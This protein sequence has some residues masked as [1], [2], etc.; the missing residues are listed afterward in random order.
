MSKLSRSERVRVIREERNK[1]MIEM[2][3]EKIRKQQEL[4]DHKSGA[5]YIND[6]CNPSPYSSSCTQGPSYRDSLWHEK[7]RPIEAEPI[8]PQPVGAPS[9]VPIQPRQWR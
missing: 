1:A 7:L 4:I 5:S 6:G 8:A 3:I 2:K 9:E